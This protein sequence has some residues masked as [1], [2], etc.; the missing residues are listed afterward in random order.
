VVPADTTMFYDD[1]HPTERGSRL[2]AETLAAYLRSR[3]PYA[4]AAETAPAAQT[5]R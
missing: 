2:F 5:P 1:V 3:P 4:R